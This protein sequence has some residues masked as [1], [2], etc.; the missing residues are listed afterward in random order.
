MLHFATPDTES[1]RGFN[2]QSANVR[3]S[4]GE[5]FSDTRPILSKSIVEDV[6]GVM[7]G[8]FTPAGS[9]PA[10]STSCSPSVCRARNTSVPS[11][12]TTV[13]TDNPSMDSERNDSMSPRPLTVVSMGRVTRASTCSGESPGDSV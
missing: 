2:V 7:R 5:S 8:V 4:I 3:S 11:L 12:N 6:S 9:V 10:V 1:N 13:M